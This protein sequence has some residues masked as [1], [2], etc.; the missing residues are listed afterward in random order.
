MMLLQAINTTGGI[1]ADWVLV[2][3]AGV[4]A[5]LLWRILNR[6]ERMLESHDKD[7]T[8]LKTDVAVLKKR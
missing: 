7:I 2:G 6:M 1:D 8:Q 4:S 3:L 5:F